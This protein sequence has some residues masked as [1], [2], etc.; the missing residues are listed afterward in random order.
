MA[1]VHAG[2]FPRTFTPD[3]TYECSE[4]PGY[5][6]LQGDEKNIKM[7]TFSAPLTRFCNFA[8]VYKY[9][10]LLTYLLTYLLVVIAFVGGGLWH[11]FVT[12]LGQP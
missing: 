8:T 11:P 12:Y 4:N 10:V 3:Y 7:C 1:T 5:A 9:L 2:T 6:I